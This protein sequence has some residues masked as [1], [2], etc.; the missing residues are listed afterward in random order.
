MPSLAQSLGYEGP[1]GVFVTPLASVASSESG[2]FGKPVTAFHYL[3]GGS[4]IGNYYTIS[5]TEGAF[6]RFEFGYTTELQEQ[7]SDHINSVNLSPLWNGTMS[8]LHGKA[9]ILPEN[10]FHTKWVPAISIGAIGRF[11]DNNVGDGSNSAA[12][13]KALSI[14]NGTQTT[15]NADIYLVG[16]KV[17]TQVTPKV[18]WLISAGVKGTDAVLWGIGGNSPNFEARA[19]GAF[20][21]VFTGP[22]KSTIILA[23]EIAQQPQRIAVTLE[24]TRRKVG[25]FDIPTSEVYAVRVVPFHR[26]KLNADFGVLQ[27]AG[28]IGA[29]PTLPSV[30]VNLN[31][32]ARFAFGLSYAF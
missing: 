13:H 2:G 8:I 22:A 7:G 3:N 19:F 16:T 27:A 11:N 25:I 17:V 28:K 14:T 31:A 18:P 32:R 29:S 24:D 6:R 23:T 5:V 4:V 12:L 20:G 30:P 26:Y 1:T 21:L 10:A 15:T 9:N